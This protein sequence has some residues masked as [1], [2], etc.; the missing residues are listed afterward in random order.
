MG[1]CNKKD[2]TEAVVLRNS[3][4][5]VMHMKIYNESIQLH[6]KLLECTDHKGHHARGGPEEASWGSVSIDQ[7]SGASNSGSRESVMECQGSHTVW[8][9]LACSPIGNQALDLVLIQPH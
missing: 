7:G 8:K 4:T 9:D 3:T 2:G 6:G 1:T 5:L